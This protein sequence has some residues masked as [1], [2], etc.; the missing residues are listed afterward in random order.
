MSSVLDQLARV[1]G[2][3]PLTD[4]L[5]L[6]EFL[7]LVP[8]PRGLRGRRYLLSSLVAA[9]A[10]S[11]LA[12]ARSLTAITEWISDAP[13]WA[14]RALGFPVHPL[15]GAVSVPHPHTLRRLFVQVDG[16]ALDRAIG[17]FLA[18]R[19]TAPGSGL[20]AIAVDGKVLRGSRTATTT[21]V[22][23]PAVMDHSGQVLA[24]R[25]IAD[26]SNEIPA[27]QPLLDSIDLTGT[28]I[29]ADAPHT[30]HAHG[31]YL[32]ERGA[33]Y[34]AQVKV[35]HPTLFDRVRHLTWQDITLDH[36]ERTRAHHR[37]EIRRLKTAS[38]AHL[39]YPDARQALQV[40]RWRKDFTTG[41]LT[42]ERVYLITSLPPGAA[43]G[44][45]LA[46][47]IKGHWKIENLLRHARD[48]TFREDDSKI[49]IGRL[50]RVMAGLRNLAIGIHRQDG[51][52]N[53]AAALR[54]TAR[55][56]RRPLTALGLTG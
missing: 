43:T 36:Y 1:V 7:D 41:K 27:F 52:T 8:D 24:Q 40:V 9:T 35:N 14:C 19:T 18:A 2:P 39:D 3:A 32:R 16:D 13:V 51:H 47:W 37:K 55:D 21:A 44:A 30:Q 12:G 6:S 49:H 42:I 50:P 34:I 31:T 48:R 25:Q 11:V 29:T 38:F 10:A 5:C 46:A 54:H 4:A 28:L 17:A 53:I 20:R 15:T 33:H 23:L 22:T 26:K 45:Q 56:C